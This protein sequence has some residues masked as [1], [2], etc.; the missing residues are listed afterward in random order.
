[1]KL[2]RT[3]SVATDLESKLRAAEMLG[4]GASVGGSRPLTGTSIATVP[5]VTGTSS[6]STI[7]T[8]AGSTGIM[9]SSSAAAG[10]STPASSSTTA[11][12]SQ[13]ITYGIKMPRYQSPGDI[14]TFVNRFEQFCL[15]HNVDEAKKANL[16]LSALDDTSFTAA[17]RELKE[18]EKK[19][20]TITKNHLLKRFDLY[21]ESGQR[22]LLFRQTKREASQ[23]MEEIYTHLLGLA[24]NAF[25][26]ENA[27]TIDKN[28]LD[29][30]LLG[31]GDD[32][33]RLYLIKKSPKTSR[34]ALSMAV[35]YKAALQYNETLKENTLMAAANIEE[36][37]YK[38]SSRVQFKNKFDDIDRSKDRNRSTSQ[39]RY[40]TRSNE[41]E[42]RG[43][44]RRNSTERNR[45]SRRNSCD[46]NSRNEYDSRRNSFDRNSPNDYNFRRN[47][48]ERN[49]GDRYGVRR[50]TS[51]ER[52]MNNYRDFDYESRGNRNGQRNNRNLYYNGNSYGRGNGRT[53]FNGYGNTNDRR[54][55]N[56]A[57]GNRARQGPFRQARGAY[58]TN[59]LEGPQCPMSVMGKFKD[60][61]VPIL[62]DTGSAVTIIN[63]EIWS[64]VKEKN[65]TL[66]E[67]SFAV[68][69]VTKQ[70][71]EILGETEIKFSSQLSRRRSTKE[72]VT[73]ALVARGILHKAIMGLDFMQQYMAQLDVVTLKM[74]LNTN[75]MKTVRNLYQSNMSDSVNTMIIEKHLT[76]VKSKTNCE[77][78]ELNGCGI[79]SD[80]K[81]Q[82]SLNKSP[83]LEFETRLNLPNASHKFRQ[84]SDR[85]DIPNKKQ[86]NYIRK[87]SICEKFRQ[88]RELH[89]IASIC[90][91]DNIMTTETS[92]TDSTSKSVLT[93]CDATEEAEASRYKTSNVTP[94]L[95]ID[96]ESIITENFNNHE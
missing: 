69:S 18:E 47:S 92:T 46:K 67:V 87:Y 54:Q 58:S 19:E 23:N 24:A 29:Q 68:R 43:H 72:F 73:T 32:K 38:R 17:N 81:Q 3:S 30:F 25:P 35:A 48:Y 71:V 36:D 89:H 39:E 52:Y 34:E 2:K 15:T 7:S 79:S 51:R 62:L 13:N 59:M 82:P 74:S 12:S 41:S 33:V 16:I 10:T 83:I 11:S 26:G 76:R 9:S 6:A 8:T 37:N 57:R 31:P 93:T 86:V 50:D 45:D 44:Y 61:E 77:K 66:K 4:K 21:K 64:L 96:D 95:S 1:M 94:Q 5:T 56:T 88:R 75:G 22:R 90:L 28:I 84:V 85:S 78:D 53:H 65:E 70:A 80:A 55:Y 27:D 60:V 49:N 91:L 40:S 20:Y 63:E 14:E 42:E